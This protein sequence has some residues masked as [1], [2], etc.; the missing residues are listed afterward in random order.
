MDHEIPLQKVL[1]LSIGYLKFIFCDIF[2]TGVIVTSAAVIQQIFV[3]SLLCSKWAPCLG[4]KDVPTYLDLAFS[5]RS[6]GTNR[7]ISNSDH[8]LKG[9]C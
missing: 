4:Q 7:V 6:T 8:E 9:N 5:W 1:F 2:F 3:R